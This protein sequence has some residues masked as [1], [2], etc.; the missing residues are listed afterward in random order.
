MSAFGDLRNKAAGGNVA[1]PDVGV[2]DG[3]ELGPEDFAFAFEGA[4][5]LLLF[6]TGFGVGGDVVEGEGGVFGSLGEAAF[7]DRG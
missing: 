2:V 6:G 3:V 5:D 7:K 1:G 4:D